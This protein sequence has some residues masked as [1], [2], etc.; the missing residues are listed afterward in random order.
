[1]EMRVATGINGLDDMLGGGLLA[2]TVA[3]VKGAPG[4]GKSVF[5]IEYL[6]RGIERFEETGLYITFE[7]FSEQLFRDAASLGFDFQKHE[8]SKKLKI[9]FSSPQTFVEQL[10]KPGGMFD[11]LVLEQGVNRIVVDSITMILDTLNPK[12]ARDFLYK[13][14]NGLRRHRA[15]SLVIQEETSLLGDGQL[16]EDG[17]SYMVD[18]LINLRYVE[19]RSAI[20]RAVMIVK[21]RATDND[22]MIHHFKITNKG[23]VIGQPFKDK[24]GLLSGTPR[25]TAKRVEELYK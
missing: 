24:E 15:T 20:E 5:G 8:K 9:L 6:A 11:L 16:A 2:G 21:Q 17:L 12:D 13:F 25:D 18:T 14:V 22:N 19:I 4:T 3:I 23:I 10:Y 7:E 1:M